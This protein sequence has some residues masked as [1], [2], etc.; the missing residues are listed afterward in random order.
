MISSRILRNVQS[1]NKLMHGQSPTS[2][3]M[4]MGAGVLVGVTIL[5]YY[6]GYESEGRVSRQ[7]NKVQ[8]VPS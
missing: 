3:G 7:R 5:V 4:F 8:A 6:A 2:R 1:G